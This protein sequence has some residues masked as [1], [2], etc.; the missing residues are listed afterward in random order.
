M[1]RETIAE[2]ILS[3]VTRRGVGK[4]ICPSEVAKALSPDDW[5]GLMESVRSV[6]F[7]LSTK[8]GI[9]ITQKGEVVGDG[10]LKGPI[11]VGLPD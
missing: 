9:A 11:R 1:T 4:T 6:A 2:E 10:A 3:Q 8:N 7:E 5:R